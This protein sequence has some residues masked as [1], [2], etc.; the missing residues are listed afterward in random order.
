MVWNLLPNLVAPVDDS[1]RVESNI[2]LLMQASMEQEVEA[3]R[4]KMEQQT[5]L[6]HL[7]TLRVDSLEKQ[8]AERPRS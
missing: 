6:L 8:L 1:S 3:L 4:E 2:F 5:A 7:L